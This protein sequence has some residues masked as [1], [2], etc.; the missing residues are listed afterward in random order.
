MENTNTIQVQWAEIC[1]QLAQSLS[2]RFVMRW[3]NK[4]VPGKLENNQVDLMVPTPC[5]H[6]LIEQNYLDKITSLWK[7]KNTAI[8][9]VNLK[10]APQAIVAQAPVLST[11][12]LRESMPCVDKTPAIADDYSLTPAKNA[13]VDIPCYLDNASNKIYVGQRVITSCNFKKLF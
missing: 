10:L 1:T 7:S 5:V 12:I 9:T 11:P 3:L 13:S 4:V 8:S 6:E 2:D